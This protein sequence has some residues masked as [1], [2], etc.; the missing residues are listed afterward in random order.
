MASTVRDIGNFGRVIW[1]LR[2]LVRH[3]IT[4]AQARATV[5]RRRQERESLFLDSVRRLIY[6]H[7]TSPY[8][9]LLRMAGCEL[10][11]LRHLVQAKGLES[12]LID[13]RQA[14][15]YVTFEEFKSK[16]PIVRGSLTLP[17]LG[18]DYDN[19]TLTRYYGHVS[20]GST[21]TPSRVHIDLDHLMDQ[22]CWI[23]L[24]YAA[25][26]VWHAPTAIWYGLHPTGVGINHVLNATRIGHAT[27]AWFAPPTTRD[28]HPSLKYRVATDALIASARLY[29]APIPRPVT[30]PLEQADKVAHWAAQ[31]L[32]EHGACLI[33]AYV[34]MCVRISQ[35][36]QEKG[37][38]LTG[39]TFMGGGEP[40]TPAKV[41]EITRSGA[42]WAANYFMAEAGALGW[43]CATP[44]DEN[45]IHHFDDMTALIQ[46]PVEVP[47]FDLTVNAF[48]FTSLLP[49]TPKVLL[50]VQSD[51]YG[52]VEQRAC[53]CLLGEAG[54]HT[55]LR[56]I[57][58]YRKITSEGVTLVG[59]DVV[60][61]LEEVLPQRFGGTA[62][63]YQLTERED[64]RGFTRL[65]LLVHPRLDIADEDEVARALYEALGGITVRTDIARAVLRQAQTVRIRREA[66]VWSAR[67]KLMPL[68]LDHQRHEQA[69]VDGPP[70][71]Q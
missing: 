67:G 26:G 54:S 21:G 8:L 68:H 65:D 44:S 32:Q 48:H 27:H 57:R 37:W 19:P 10:G 18:L 62:L 35:A 51:D 60:R 25:H 29:G 41:R 17:A 16:Q 11:D 70:A 1:G 36:A 66:P 40:P 64:E 42:R 63:D 56:N 13:L 50:N 34:S 24:A 38:D 9:A 7:P 5:E 61:V 49:S 59:S 14:G 69:P 28:V 33:R 15:V 53:G 46:F 12:A 31:A 52:V 4:L 6:D 3:P 39:A 22:A 71:E 55:H 2:D 20:G 43:S 58:S 47:G 23:L 30:T 45:D